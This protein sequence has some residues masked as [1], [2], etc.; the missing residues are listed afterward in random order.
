LRVTVKH[1]AGDARLDGGRELLDSA[2]GDGGALRVAAADDDG[3]GALAG[4]QLIVLLASAM[5]LGSPPPGIRLP[6][7]PAP[8]RTPS[9]ARLGILRRM[10]LMRPGPIIIPCSCQPV[11]G[12]L[13]RLT[14]DRFALEGA[15]H[16]DE[17]DG[18]ARTLGQLMVAAPPAASKFAFCTFSLG[19]RTCKGGR[20]QRSVVRAFIVRTRGEHQT[21][22]ECFGTD[23][24]NKRYGTAFMSYSLL[25]FYRSGIFSSDT[26]MAP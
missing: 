9:A 1:D 2:V 6:A 10:A 12:C 13:E 24:V 18:L 19:C 15:A 26:V 21:D 17:G 8:Y 22:R 20:S 11:V 25:C 4:G 7:T 14:Y 16:E 3:V 5:P 23:L